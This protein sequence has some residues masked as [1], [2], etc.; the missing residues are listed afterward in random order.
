MRMLVYLL[1][2]QMSL[3]LFS[4]FKY[5][6]PWQLFP[7]FCLPGSLYILLPHS[8]CN[9]FILVY[10]SL[11]TLYHSPLFVVLQ[12][13][14][15]KHFLNLFSV[16]LHSFSEILDHLC[17]YY[18]EYFFLGSLPISTLLSCSSGVLSCSFVWDVFF[19]HLILCNFLWLQFP[20]CRLQ[21]C[22]F[23]CFCSLPPG[24]WGWSKKL[25]QASW[26]ERLVLAHSCVEMGLVP[27]VGRTVSKGVFS[28]KLWAQKDFRLPSC[29]WVGLCSLLV[30]CLAWGIPALEPTG[31]WVGLGLGGF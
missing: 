23:S 15:V 2:S 9:W 26:W 3:R 14:W 30:G 6:V 17:Y 19:R 25:A 13:F 28:R 1:L 18:S 27:L 31:C 10:F 4:F 12:F 8:F 11:Q 5:S 29:C 24:E 16:C 7:P 20:F 22:S 21:G